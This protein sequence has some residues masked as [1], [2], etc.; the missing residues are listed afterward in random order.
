[1]NLEIGQVFR[2]PANH[3]PTPEVVD[4]LPNYFSVTLLA[5]G[6]LAALPKG[7]N[8]VSPVRSG[9]GYR[10][11][12]ILIRSSPRIAGTRKAPWKDF[13]DP[14]RGHVRFFGDNKL[15]AGGQL[16]QPAEA[17]GNK[18]LLSEWEKHSSTDVD[19][20]A[21][22][23]PLVFFEAVRWEDRLTGNVM[24][25]GFGVI[26]R[27]ELVTQWD[28]STE[29]T[30]ANFMYDFAVLS[31]RYEGELF[32]WSWIHGR[33][34]RS[35]TDDHCFALAPKSWQ[36]WVL[37]GEAALPVLRRQVT[38]PGLRSRAEQ[39][40]LPGTREDRTL[41]LIYEFFTA[42]GKH[43]FEAL[44]EMVTED[45]LGSNGGNYRSGWITA[46]SGDRGADFY[47]RLDVGTGFS[48]AKVIVL[49]QAKCEAPNRAAGGTAIA[50]TA[51][52]LRRGW[53]GVFV[54]T[55]YFSIQVQEEVSEDEYP[56]VLVP[57]REVAESVHRIMTSRGR[58]ITDASV[59]RFLGEVLASHPG[60]IFHRH[61]SELLLDGAAEESTLIG[62]DRAMAVL[63]PEEAPASLHEGTASQS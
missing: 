52:R 53:I 49:G 35:Q 10:R 36:G 48:T 2:Y 56:L 9:Q 44:A 19:T 38:A 43:A 46:R 26:E 34:A 60:R 5:D 16:R 14:D 8:P 39:L 3:Q 23:T 61:P 12:V 11:P 59:R 57:G 30:F 54:T 7:I 63:V 27:I 4:D 58:R 24:F 62:M 31:M 20:R 22:A 55:G 17:P 1:M 6:K 47:G 29:R 32:D 45:I 13:L 50:R 42:R 18:I 40:P 41:R 15:P 25:K 33:S 37:G 28:P 21:K 51:A